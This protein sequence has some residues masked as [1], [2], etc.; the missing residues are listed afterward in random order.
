MLMKIRGIMSLAGI[1]R[2]NLAFQQLTGK[3][4][5]SKNLMGWLT[6]AQ[7]EPFTEGRT[8]QP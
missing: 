2:Q 6:I 4:L 1:F 8:L 7:L 5:I 3:I